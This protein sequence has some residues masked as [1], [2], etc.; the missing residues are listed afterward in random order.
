MPRQP[1]LTRLE[2]IYQAIA[3]HPGSRPGR[4]ARLL[5]EP[6]SQITRALPALETYG[7][8]V[9]EDERGRLWPFRDSV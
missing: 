5:G 9:S 2:Q 6:R 4:I 8:L 3:R 7:F 1:D